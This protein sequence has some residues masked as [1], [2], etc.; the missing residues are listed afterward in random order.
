[1]SISSHADTDSTNSVSEYD[2]VHDPDVSMPIEA[3]GEAP[4]S[5]DLNGDVDMQRDGDDEEVEDEV[6]EDE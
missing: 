6:E 1:M 3:D 5:I 4:D 2:S